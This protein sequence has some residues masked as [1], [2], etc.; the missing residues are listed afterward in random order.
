MAAA[1]AAEVPVAGC[2]CAFVAADALSAA[3]FAA[4]R[5]AYRCQPQTEP[6]ITPTPSS[7]M[8]IAA[9][10]DPFWGRR[11]RIFGKRRAVRALFAVSE[12]VL[13]QQTLF[14]EPEV[15]RDSAH[16]SA[17]K[18]AAGQLFPVLAFKRFEKTRRDARRDRHFVEG[19]FAQLALA[20][21]KFAET[22]F[23]HAAE[24]RVQQ[25]NF[26]ATVGP[27]SGLCGVR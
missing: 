22:S 4:R 12:I 8:A 25:S 9:S 19:H 13:R 23:V 3:R 24:S 11:N 15:T 16:K 20:L 27:L 2:A 10:H 18:N 6:Q 17:I 21:Q 5:A 7:K 14:V 1:G 26:D